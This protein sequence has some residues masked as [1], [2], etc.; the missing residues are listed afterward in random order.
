MT[1]I[2][3]AASNRH[4]RREHGWRVCS[5]Q[6]AAY[7][8]KLCAYILAS[9]TALAN[10]N[11]VTIMAR[12][13]ARRQAACA[14]SPRDKRHGSMAHQQASAATWRIIWRHRCAWRNIEQRGAALANSE[15]QQSAECM[16]R[17]RERNAKRQQK[18]KPAA[19]AINVKPKEKRRQSK[20]AAAK[21][22]G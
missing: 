2:N 19:K 15:A 9:K 3:A 11:G 18:R 5:H 14:R 16:W 7:N 21:K 6:A 13:V 12:Y 1:A 22:I 17:K 20:L 4:A 8:R 10:L